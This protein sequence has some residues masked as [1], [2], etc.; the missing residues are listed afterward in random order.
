VLV[1]LQMLLLVQLLVVL[2]MLQQLIQPLL[3]L[4]HW[5]CYCELMFHHLELGWIEGYISWSVVDCV[6]MMGVLVT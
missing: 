2:I 6:M 1:Q 5:R 4:Q 3:L